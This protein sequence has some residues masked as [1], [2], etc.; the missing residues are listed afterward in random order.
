MYALAWTE[1]TGTG[2]RNG[3]GN[4]VIEMNQIR[5]GKHGEDNRDGEDG[6]GLPKKTHCP[7]IR[8]DYMAAKNLN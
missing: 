4:R 3:C 5:E 7:W 2:K 6:E 8:V 1:G